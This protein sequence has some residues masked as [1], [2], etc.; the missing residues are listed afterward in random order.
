[1][2]R[3]VIVALVA[4][5]LGSL[6]WAKGEG[7]AVDQ[8]V[9]T[10]AYPVGM[11][12]AE[13]IRESSGLAV[14]RQFPGVIWTHNDSGD[15]A[16]L[17]A[18]GVDGRLIHPPD[19]QPADYQGIAV[20]GARHRD[21]EDIAIGADGTLYIG[22][23][24]NNRSR[25]R[26]LGVYVVAEPDP[27]VDSQTAPARFIPVYYP[28]QAEFPD[29]AEAFDCEAMFYAQGSLYLLTKQ[30]GDRQ[31]TLYRMPLDTTEEPVALE[32]MG[33][34][35]IEGLVTAADVSEDGREL[36]V[37]T[38]DGLWL[39][40]AEEP[41]RWLDNLVARRLIDNGTK[42]PKDRYRNLGGEAVAFVDDQILVSTEER[43]LF[44]FDR[45]TLLPVAAD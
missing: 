23:V 30:R 20:T 28:E 24:G 37:L 33:S 16:R 43:Q 42:T 44:L 35:D 36:L 4:G 38:Y 18:I 27:R 39:F 5:G 25:R 3:L 40:R 32:R 17:F 8:E 7:V 15:K 34:F 10:K 29:P 1:M 19:V 14:S 31:T 45:A 9:P 13:M 11:I 6:L 21:W 22:D 41:G 26:D 2:L 12:E